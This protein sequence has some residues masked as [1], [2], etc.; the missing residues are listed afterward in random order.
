MF[1][2]GSLFLYYIVFAVHLFLISSKRKSRRICFFFGITILTLFSGLRY[3]V[4]TDYNNYVNNYYYVIS[5]T[6]ILNIQLKE[7]L[8]RLLCKIASLFDSY[9][10]LFLFSSFFTVLFMYLGIKKLSK[11]WIIPYSMYLFIFFPNTYN[12]V[13]QGFAQ[14]IVLFATSYIFEKRLFA[15]FNMILAAFFIHMSS[16]CT[17]LF[18]FI[19]YHFGLNKKIKMIKI[20]IFIL[21]I[22]LIC[23]FYKRLIY[24]FS[25]MH[26]DLYRY[27]LYASTLTIGKN[28]DFYLKIVQML[29]LLIFL[30]RLVKIESRNKFYYLLFILSVIFNYL[31]FFN[32]FIKRISI[33]FEMYIIFILEDLIYCFR[34][35]DK[36]IIK[37]SLYIYSCGYFYIFY[38]IMGKSQIFPYKF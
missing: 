20:F 25:T 19:Y 30:K 21:F 2:I 8:F 18:Y 38:Y 14:S 26:P 35:K 12:L 27:K 17:L 33:Y 3:Q 22:C 24:I 37:Y 5:N 6:S 31:G 9:R 11:N 28:R 23:I 4:G 7:F 10:F 1:V 15:Y 29:I 13:R 34:K 16:F 36:N 32:P